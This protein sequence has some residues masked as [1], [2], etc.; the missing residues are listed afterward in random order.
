MINYL[1]S[2]HSL[3]FR[4]CE[5]WAL[6]MIFVSHCG[7]IHVDRWS[8][9]VY[10]RQHSVVF[11]GILI[12]VRCCRFN[13]F[14]IFLW[15]FSIQYVCAVICARVSKYIPTCKHFIIYI[16]KSTNAQTIL[17]LFFRFDFAQFTADYW[18]RLISCKLN[19]NLIRD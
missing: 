7:W 1:H 12:F 18:N 9:V 5:L 2:S 6:K 4:W 17:T 16:M 3:L 10:A 13:R 11:N 14:G 8:T 19:L 15:L